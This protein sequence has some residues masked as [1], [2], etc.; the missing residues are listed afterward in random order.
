[1]RTVVLGEQEI[2]AFMKRG[3][4]LKEAQATLLGVSWP[5]Q[6]GWKETILGDTVCSR[7]YDALL[8]YR[9]NKPPS[10]R[11]R[12]KEKKASTPSQQFLIDGK[13][14]RGGWN[15]R[16]LAAVGIK[17]PPAPGWRE[18]F[19]VEGLSDAQK[20]LFLDLKGKAMTRMSKEEKADHKAAAKR[21][22]IARIEAE[23]FHPPERRVFTRR[24][25]N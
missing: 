13:S 8:Y 17:W 4:G 21:E 23:G 12:R 5:L 14:E 11:S 25:G 2:E 7:L 10:G 16:Q 1:M 20:K 15:A 3:V 6:E 19:R 22:A 18:R 24:A 9:D